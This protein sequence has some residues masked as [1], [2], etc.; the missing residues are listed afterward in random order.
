MYPFFPHKMAKIRYQKKTSANAHYGV[1]I[2]WKA[3]PIINSLEIN[4]TKSLHDL[5]WKV[6]E[7]IK[8][9]KLVD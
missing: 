5:I 1:E 8:E 7:T 9:D 6:D 2:K 4:S 3:A